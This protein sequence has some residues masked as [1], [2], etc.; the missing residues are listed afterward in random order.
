MNADPTDG[1]FRT[2]LA[3]AVVGEVAARLQALAERGEESAI[4]LRSLPLTPGDRRELENRLGHGEV[5]AGLDIGGLSEVWECG[6]AGVW[7]VRH[8]GEDG[9]PRSERIEIAAVPAILVS[10]TGDIAAAAARLQHDTTRPAKE[11]SHHA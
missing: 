3:E 2:G 6:Y 8:L 10:H 1:G 5:C 7:W 9:M 11:D 4:D